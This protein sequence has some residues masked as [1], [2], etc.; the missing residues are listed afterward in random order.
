MLAY[1]DFKKVQ[2]S[3]DCFISDDRKI[4]KNVK[5]AVKNVLFSDEYARFRGIVSSSD[6]FIITC[7]ILRDN[8]FNFVTTAV[9][10]EV[11]LRKKDNYIVSV[12]RV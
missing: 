5:K 6:N 2:F 7:E 11:V 10:V 3:S 9:V 4:L 1:R 12:K 8:L